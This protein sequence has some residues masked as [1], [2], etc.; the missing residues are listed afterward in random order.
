MTTP[1]VRNAR[2][3]ATA[4]LPAGHEARVLE[5]SAPAN[6]DPAWFADDPTD[7]GDATGTIVTPIPGEGTTW[8]EIAAEHPD[9]AA[10]A[11]DHWLGSY[12]RLEE[13]PAGFATGRDAL[14]QLSFFAVAPKRHAETG[15]LALRYTHGGFGTPYFSA[16]EQVRVEGNLLILQQGNQVRSTPITTLKAATEFLGISYQDVWFEGFHDPLSSVGADTGLLVPPEVTTAIGEWFGFGSS[17]LEEARRTPDAEDVGRVQLWPEHFDSAFEM[18]SNDQ[19]RRASYGASPG[20][21]AHPEPYLYV[22]A[23]G[24]I[25]R[26][27]AYWNDETF[28]GASLSYRDLLAADDQ[29]A[30]ALAFVD[31]GFKRLTG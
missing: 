10:F 13:L 20:D 8:T 18:G 15:K 25:D 29:R 16:D 7:P 19:G 22:A 21:A 11:S 1:T 28:N 31:D 30:T 12:R 23:W 14:H 24:E 6:P 27:D 2:A 3:E 9:L 17:V 4:L 26:S 5:P